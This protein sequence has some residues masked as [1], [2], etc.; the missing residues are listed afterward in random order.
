MSAS[1]EQSRSQRLHAAAVLAQR[2]SADAVE[3]FLRRYYRHVAAED[4]LARE[5][6]DLLGAALAH[7]DLARQRAVGTVNVSVVNPSIESE[8][9]TSGHTV[10]QVVTDDM[11][12]LVDSEPRRS[13]RPRLT[14]AQWTAGLIAGSGVLGTP[15]GM[16]RIAASASGSGTAAVAGM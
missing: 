2:G 16:P 5:P 4:L 6:G 12:F 7:E 15:P 3:A 9:W 8:G 11:P 1:L 13:G 10:V 14:E